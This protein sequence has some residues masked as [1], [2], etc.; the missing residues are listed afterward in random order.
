MSALPPFAWATAVEACLVD[1][2]LRW[3]APLAQSTTLRIG[4]LADC[5][6]DLESEAELLALMEVVH[7]HQLPFYVMGKGSNLLLPDE[8][9]RGVVLR[10]GKAF[11]T[12]QLQPLP[13]GSTQ[14]SA[15][16][17]TANAVLVESC[18]KAG[19]KG[20]EFMVA[21]PGNVGGAVAMNAGAYGTETKDHLQLV[22]YYHP[23]RG[24]VEE[25]AT[26]F[27]FAY[28]HS[29]LNGQRGRVVLGATFLLHPA[30]P[31]EIGQRI[32]QWQAQRKASQPR[33]FPNCGSVFKNPPGDHAGRLIEACGLKGYSLGQVQVS[34]KHANFIVNRGGGTAVEVQTLVAHIQKV[35]QQQ[36]GV[37]LEPE[38]QML[39]P[40]QFT[41]GKA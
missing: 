22:R 19:L 8:G 36:T 1:S 13:N 31:A 34:E 40:A 30:N 39:K 21:I 27:A 25:A 10:L 41:G 29:P 7:Q 26:E 14:V 5:L 12:H 4:G 23:D 37:Q 32:D 28:R 18:R 15:G 17:A 35:V 6:V 11:R 2:R 33:D 9:L 3:N 16:A 20:L 24:I 38:V